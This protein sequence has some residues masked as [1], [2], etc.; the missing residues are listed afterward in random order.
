MYLR[1]YRITQDAFCLKFCTRP[2]V[3]NYYNTIIPTIAGLSFARDT[4]VT[5]IYVRICT[6]VQPHPLYISH[7]CPMGRGL[8]LTI[9]L[10]TVQVHTG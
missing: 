2:A 9:D 3:H 8:C 5:F 1:V 6:Y 7:Y 4:D 10:Y